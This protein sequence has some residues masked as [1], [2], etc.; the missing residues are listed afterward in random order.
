MV[1]T[2]NPLLGGVA[3][4][5]A[6]VACFARSMLFNSVEARMIIGAKQFEAFAQNHY[7]EFENASFAAK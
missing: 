2:T 6:G 4:R 5:K 1:E 7:L 3:I